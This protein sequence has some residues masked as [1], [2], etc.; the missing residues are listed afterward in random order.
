MNETERSQY[1]KFLNIE[2]LKQNQQ[3][4]QNY[5]SKKIKINDVVC[6]GEAHTAETI[7]KTAVMGF[8][9]QAQ[10][11]GLTDVGLEIEERLQEYF[12]RYLETGKFQETDNPDD[13]EKVAEYQ[14]L[15][16]KWHKTHEVETLKTMSAFEKT[17]EDN[18]VLSG[19]LHEYYYLL[20]RARELGLRVH[21]IDSNQKHTQEEIDKAFDSGTYTEWKQQKEEERD[22]RM[23]ANIR[24]IVASGKGKIL[25]LL[26]AAHIAKGEM[27]HKNLGDLLSDDTTLKSFRVNVDRNFDIDV[28]AQET[29]QKLGKSINLNS[30]LYNALEKQ[31]IG[32]VGFDLDDS[33]L[34]NGG[35][36][37]K[38]FPFDGYVKI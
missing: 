28:T 6:L 18:F 2:N 36:Q 9:E 30:V 12:D 17:V 11:N 7:E 21:C 32:Q 15:R 13:Y 14:T 35:R 20:K 4:W 25:V 22:Q 29:K 26:G 37:D 19:H 1:E 27:Q 10:E 34:I 3:N 31:G 8:L 33:V 24:N 16:N 23:F 5:L 38:N